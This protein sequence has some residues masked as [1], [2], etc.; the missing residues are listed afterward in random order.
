[1]DDSSSK[2]E[3]I[4]NNYRF[5]LSWRYGIFGG[6][7]LLL[8]VVLKTLCNLCEKNVNPLIIGLFLFGASVISLILWISD[9]RV[10]RIYRTLI[11]NGT[12]LEENGNY[13]YSTLHGLRKRRLKKWNPFSHS[14]S[15]DSIAFFNF[16]VFYSLGI[17]ALNTDNLLKNFNFNISSFSWSILIF[18]I[19]AVFIIIDPFMLRYFY[20]KKNNHDDGSLSTM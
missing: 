17:I 5:Y 14:F 4:G 10:R 9:L 19:L 13:A 16:S 2:Y 11:Y 6:Q 15:L 20:K 3:E 12:R 7:L 8:W 18:G 1:M